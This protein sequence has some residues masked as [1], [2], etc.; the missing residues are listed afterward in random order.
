MVER[1][2]FTHKSKLSKS[3]TNGNHYGSILQ[4]SYSTIKTVFMVNKQER[5]E[6]IATPP[7][8]AS[9]IGSARVNKHFMLEGIT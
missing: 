2:P 9:S 5:M 4:S 8:N 3:L 7:S 6:K 1:M